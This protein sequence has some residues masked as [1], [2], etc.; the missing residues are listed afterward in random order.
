[1]KTGRLLR[2]QTLSRMIRQRYLYLLL[3]PGIV[4]LF[5][6][7][8]MPIYGTILAFKDYNPMLGMG[9][10]PFLSPWYRNFVEMVDS[11]F[12]K[13]VLRNTLLINLYGVLFGFP[14]PLVL[15]LLL[16]EVRKRGLKRAVQTVTYMPHFLSWVIVGGFV[17]EVLS[18]SHGMVAWAGQF[19]GMN[20]QI[21]ILANPRYFRAVVIL[22]DIWKE[23]GWGS[24]IY[25]AAITAINP[26][27]YDAAEVDGAGRLRQ[28]FAIT[29]PSIMPTIMALLVLRLGNMLRSNFEQIFV[30]SSPST[31]SVADVISTFV[32]R[33]GI[34]KGDYSF[35]TAVGLFSSVIGFVLI[36]SANAGARRMDTELW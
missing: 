28:T 29:I 32:Y 14:A 3:V 34:R 4:T 12:F 8:Y 13:R 31:M 25:L 30:L 36:V 7:N 26:D 19:L 9:G 16:N 35:A 1:M 11:F 17:V 5:V 20:S 27:Y 2:R 6:F 24:I 23:V 15:A 21:A 33:E 10:S 18:P 22:S